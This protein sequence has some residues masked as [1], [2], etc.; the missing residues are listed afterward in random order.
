MAPASKKAR[1]A[2]RPVAGGG[3]T[4]FFGAPAKAPE[5][6]AEATT[7]AAPAPAPEP[8]AAPT[9]A[10]QSQ[11]GPSSPPPAPAAASQPSAPHEARPIA[12]PQTART[13]PPSLS[14]SPFLANASQASASQAT[15]QASGA[16]DLSEEQRRRIEE[17]RRKAMEKKRAREEVAAAA[18]AAAEPQALEAALP[19]AA[20]SPAAAEEPKA[21]AMPEPKPAAKA[22]SKGAPKAAAK[23]A[24]KAKAKAAAKVSSPDRAASDDASTPDK[25]AAKSPARPAA[26]G[27]RTTPNVAETTPEKTAAPSQGSEKARPVGVP[28]EACKFD[29]LASGVWSQY[30]SLYG[31][32]L[33][34]LRG[35]VLEQA[36]LLWGGML[37]PGAFQADITGYRQSSQG[38]EVVL[39]GVV[40][41]SL[42]ERSNI[43]ELYRNNKIGGVPSDECVGYN[44]PKLCS[45]SDELFLEDHVMRVQLEVPG[46]LR[47]RLATGLVVAVRGAADADGHFKTSAMCLARVPSPAPLPAPEA[48]TGRYLALVSGLGGNPDGGAD[49]DLKAAR[50]KCAEFLRSGNVHHVVVCGGTL[51]GLSKDK[52]GAREAL[53]EAD[54]LLAGIAEKVPVHVL[55]GRGEPTSMSLPQMPLHPHLFKRVQ[56]HRHNFK[57][58]S[59]PHSCSVGGVKLLGHSGQ[60]IEDLMRCTSIPTPLEALLTTLEALHLAPTAPDTLATQPFTEADPFVIDEVPHVLFAGGCAQA[61]HEWRP[62]SRG[63]GGTICVC[64][65]AFHKQPA[66]VLVN[67]HD[68]RD[69][70]VQE[71]TGSGGDV[72]MG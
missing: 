50:A 39:V 3:L 2:A 27:T 36:R 57:A 18:A 35:L 14:P 15:S 16:G 10:P 40:F 72:R 5:A 56:A 23:G 45:D 42:E 41:R 24:A 69:V 53:E 47:A 37:E 70:K 32:R 28:R 8:A 63:E 67:L 30:N 61:A 66:V 38:Q 21:E 19:A 13:G 6:P 29:R 48:S 34:K 20:A 62:S 9:T 55:P 68:P 46:E 54:A 44:A 43:I 49:E 33:Q 1:T 52:D 58:V 11:Q 26:G 7:A 65:P 31:V 51:T 25:P 12:T 22:K 59:N 4:K 17:N 64:V 60:P 71:F